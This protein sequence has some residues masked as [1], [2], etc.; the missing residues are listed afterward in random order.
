M[1][2]KLN[3]PK[4]TVIGIDIGKNSLHVVGMDPRGAI[5]LR[6]TWS[7]S[8]VQARLANMR[9]CLIRMQHVSEPV[10]SV[11]LPARAYSTCPPSAPV[12]QIWRVERRR[13]SGSS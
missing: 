4:A 5:V 6:Q 10:I 3:N 12:R 11:V 1:P 2:E 9:P 13:I 8:Q 7:R